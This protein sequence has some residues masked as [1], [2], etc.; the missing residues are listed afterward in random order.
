[1]SLI[2]ATAKHNSALWIILLTIG[3]LLLWF[4]P[5]QSLFSYAI[6]FRLCIA[7]IIFIVP[8][9]C[10]YGLV[11]D[12]PTGWLNHVTFGFVIS[13]L[14]LAAFGTMGRFLHFP[15]DVLKHG[16]MALGLILLL[17]YAVSNLGSI[18]L[19]R[20][21]TPTFRSILSTWPLILMVV[22]AGLMTIQRVLSDDDLTYLALLNNWQNSPALNFN[23][24]FFGVEK[25]LSVRFW[26]VSTPFSQAFLAELSG[27]PGIF[28]LGGY[29]E[30]FLG[31]LSLFSVYGLARTLGLTRQKAM[32][33][34]AFQVVSLALLSEYLHPGA[35]FLR[36]L[37]TDK[38]TA[39]FIIIPVFIQSVVWYLREPV[40]RNIVLVTLTGL[41]LMMMHPVALV[42]AITIVGLITIFGLDRTNWR[43]RLILLVLLVLIMSPQIAMRFV[44]SEAQAVIPYAAEDV[45]TS[46]GIESL[47]SV[48][49][50]TSFYGY[51]PSILAMHIPYAERL[52]IHLNL[53]FI[54]LIFPFLE[55]IYAIK[56]I[57]HDSLSQYIL[58][59]F[60]LGAFAGIPFTGWLLG[61]LVSAWMLERT[62]WLYPFGIGMVFFL[63]ALNDTANLTGRMIIWT[64]A[65][66][67][68][69]QFD[70]AQWAWTT[71]TIFSAA[72]ILLFMREQNLPNLSRLESS[73][74]RYMEFSQIGAFM[75]SHTMGQTIAVG[76]DS[77][78]DYIPA[79]TSKV[80][81]ISYRPSDPSY[82]YFY[83]EE[84]RDQRLADRQSIFSRNVS[85]Q[86]RI[87]LIRKYDVQ[88]LWLKEG[89]YYMVKKMVSSFPNIFSEHKFEGYYLIEVR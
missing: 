38:A 65:L 30:P 9:S 76:T 16:M 1:M 14:I 87:N 3:W 28:L 11:Q 67:T 5:W 23:D 49:D 72:I 26:L 4:A 51:N 37:S 73:T 62:L 78:N 12:K 27:L 15:F 47:V 79:I 61:S 74:Q 44:N 24:V 58:A 13:H 75:D 80:K 56:R 21:T 85:L 64:R 48:W 84:E 81:L 54:W 53:Q 70:P 86:E 22:L 32:A 59:C 41:S 52:P 66:H 18:R 89:E 10:I 45:L 29:Y 82:P 83:S 39:A 46:G 35:P 55:A 77:L 50:N 2:K 7:L 33:A 43:A 20:F 63:I 71:L 57:R 40:K 31:A 19:P 69:I 6:W 8:G 60:L 68:K 88:F 17:F 36:Q 25:L 34:V 42:F